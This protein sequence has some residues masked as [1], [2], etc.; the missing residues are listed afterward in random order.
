VPIPLELGA[1]RF[2]DPRRLASAIAAKSLLDGAIWNNAQG[3]P[4]SLDYRYP[5]RRAGGDVNI[6]QRPRLTPQ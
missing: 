4:L 3:I 5:R 1:E 2:A 6:H